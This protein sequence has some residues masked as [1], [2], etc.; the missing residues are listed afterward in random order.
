[1]K[2]L[3][4]L[5]VFCL[6]FSAAYSQNNS[7]GG[8]ARLQQLD[9]Q[10]KLAQDLLS[11]FPNEQAKDLLALVV[12]ARTDIQLL[13]E[14]R[15]NALA[16]A[17]LLVAFS[18][19]QK[20]IDQLSQNPLKRI[21]EEVNELLQNTEQALVGKR[22]NKAAERL[23]Q[24]AKNN[25]KN[26]NNSFERGRILMAV[27]NYRVAKFLLERCLGLVGDGKL[28]IFEPLRNEKERYEELLQR[29]EDVVATC[30]NQQAAK[31]L[32]EAQKQD[33]AIRR[34][35]NQ[36]NGKL[37]LN[38]YYSTT[39]LLLRA[40]DMCQGFSMPA[41][42]QALEDIE[43]LRNLYET[44][45]EENGS[46]RSKVILN[47]VLNLQNQAQSA[48][49]R[50]NF[51]LAQ[52]RI[53]LARNLL[54]R[55]WSDG[56]EVNKQERAFQELEQLLFDIQKYQERINQDS[57][58]KNKN[59]LKAAQASANDARRFLKRNW[60]NVALQ[61]ILAGNRFLSA[62]DSSQG[63]N[64]LISKENIEIE[65]ER[66]SEKISS[67]QEDGS[68]ERIRAARQMLDKAVQALNNNDIEIASE[69]VRLGNNLL[70]SSNE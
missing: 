28:D 3:L 69:Y 35:V 19:V 68:K 44:A 22:N 48:I 20:V 16:N 37:A 14:S 65:I 70:T 52:R 32:L 17:Q 8:E 60:T 56:S 15:R 6:L 61:S 51:L 43:M 42:D 58:P 7:H 11:Q 5:V 10:I 21:Q 46:G 41:K 12:K 67:I 54:G 2:Y 23:L 62:L 4:T 30:D 25:I 49:N 63:G 59:L 26:G 33:Q 24:D 31:L 64:N 29:A 55:L 47:K 45:L 39:R 66:L 13:F 36:G 40:I 34:A 9:S 53:D 27:E 1:M 57:S 50:G 38:L 18:L